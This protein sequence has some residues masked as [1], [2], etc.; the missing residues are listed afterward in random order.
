MEVKNTIS[1]MNSNVD[2]NLFFKQD[3]CVPVFKRI[4][5]KKNIRE[6]FYNKVSKIN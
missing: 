3:F 5:F 4:D 2:F 6:W 1:E